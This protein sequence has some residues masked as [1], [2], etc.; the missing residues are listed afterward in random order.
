LLVVYAVVTLAS[1]V[2]KLYVNIS[3]AVGIF[4]CDATIT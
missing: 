3:K 4:C 1:K 2:L